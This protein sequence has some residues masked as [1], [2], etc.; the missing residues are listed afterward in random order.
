MDT[1][2]LKIVLENNQDIMA[3]LT[4]IDA[5]ALKDSWLCA[6]TIRNFIWNYLSGNDMLDYLTDIDVIFYDQEISYEQ[7]QKI[8]QKLKL[9]YP[10]YTWELKNQVYMHQYNPHTCPYKSSTDAISKFPETCTAIGIR[11]TKQHEIELFTPYGIDDL[12]CFRVLPTP[13]YLAHADRICYYNQRVC[14]KNWQTKW[15]NLSITLI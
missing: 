10:S 12:L 7:T 13:Y 3:I 6:G 4:I 2:D 8:E 5:L 1:S 11:L 9:A 14:Q 15:E